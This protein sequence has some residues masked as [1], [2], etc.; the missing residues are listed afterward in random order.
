MTRDDLFTKNA[1]IVRD[2]AEACAKYC[3]GANLLIIANPVNSTVPIVAEIF[4]KHKVF[5]PKRLFGV[6]TLDVTR[7][8]TFVAEAKGVDVNTIDIPVIGGHA[9]KTILPLLSQVL[10]DFFIYF[11]IIYYIFMRFIYLFYS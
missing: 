5:N 7:A 2:L 3:P 10:F 9:G 1:S 11:F 4:K 6:T 8:R